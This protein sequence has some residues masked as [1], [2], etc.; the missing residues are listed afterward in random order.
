MT[1][2]QK[3][4]R[5]R[6]FRMLD[7]VFVVFLLGMIGTVLLLG[8][9]NHMETEKVENMRISAT[10]FQS[11]LEAGQQLREAGK[12]TAPIVCS[13]GPRKVQ[14]AADT[15]P[16]EAGNKTPG[17]TWHDC[18]Q[19]LQAPGQEMGGLLNPLD[20]SSLAFAGKCDR[21]SLPTMGA[22]IVEKGMVGISG[23]T[24]VIA[25][26]PIADHDSLH[27]EVLLRISVCGRGFMTLSVD[28]L[29]F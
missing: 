21:N 22:I 5:P 4:E 6:Y 7:L 24:Q 16:E 2:Q 9:H 28:E 29:K 12:P 25:Y 13:R 8:H 10:K 26:A 19:A 17:Y 18:I 27:D 14:V 11:W 15:S 3:T 23:T 20:P 1:D